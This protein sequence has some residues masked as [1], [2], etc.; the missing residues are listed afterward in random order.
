M[1]NWNSWHHTEVPWWLVSSP[2]SSS[3]PSSTFTIFISWSATHA[4]TPSHMVRNGRGNLVTKMTVIQIV[5][6]SCKGTE[7]TLKASSTTS[8]EKAMFSYM[9][10]HILWN[11]TGKNATDLISNFF[12][13]AKCPKEDC[14]KE[15]IWICQWGKPFIYNSSSCT[16]M[17][18]SSIRAKVFS[19]G[20]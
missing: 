10:V 18:Q 2:L 20:T 4:H 9:G 14:F 12:I 16:R 7:L 5:L 1:T 19:Q 15:L 3:I 17:L 11:L 8:R 13:N 6:S